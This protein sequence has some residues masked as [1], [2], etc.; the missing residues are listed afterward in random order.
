MHVFNNTCKKHQALLMLT[1]Q[2][3]YFRFLPLCLTVKKKYLII[4]FGHLIPGRHLLAGAAVG[5]RMIWTVSGDS[6]AVCI[7]SAVSSSPQASTLRPLPVEIT[8]LIAF[9][10]YSA[11]V[12]FKILVCIFNIE[13][14]Q[15]T[16]FQDKFK[17]VLLEKSFEKCL[18]TELSCI[19]ATLVI[20]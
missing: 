10:R 1:K 6:S 5:T 19:P 16:N 4:I 8:C 17:S 14:F 12:F 2:F 3:R 18:L 20:K 13:I 11:N 7:V 15:Q 9:L